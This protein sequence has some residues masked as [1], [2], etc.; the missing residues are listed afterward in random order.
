MVADGAALETETF[1]LSLSQQN[2]WNLEQAYPG[3]SINNISTTIRIQGRIDFNALQKSVNLVL[4]SDGSLRTRIFRS[5]GG[6]VQYHAPYTKEVFPVLDFSHTSAKGMESWEHA[7][8][9]EVIPLEDGPLYRFVLFRTGENSGGVLIKVHHIISDG[10]AQVLLCNRIGQTYLDLLSD[11]AVELEESPSYRL[12]VLEEQEYLKSSAYQKD[13]AYWS[14]VMRDAGEPSM[15]KQV[16]SAAVSPVG[17]RSSFR[18]PDVINH[19]IYSFC[20]QNRVAPF[21]VFYMALA[22]YF[23]RIGGAD[24]FT[25][26]VPIY[27][28][29]SFVSKQTTGMFVSTL[30]FIS[31]IHEEWSFSEFNERLAENWYELLRHQKFPFEDIVRMAEDEQKL[32]GRLFHIALSYQDSTILK[33]KDTSVHFSG[34]WHYNGYQAEHLCIHLSNL[35]DNRRY[36]VDYDYLTQ[37]YSDREIE[38]LHRCLLNILQEAL[39]A[40][41]RPI[42][43]LSVLGSE[44]REQVLYTFNRTLKAVPEEGLYR[45]FCRQVEEHPER[46]AAICDGARVS[47][48]ELEHMAYPVYEA[49]RQGGVMENALVAVFLPKKPELL[50]AMVGI[51]RAGCAYLLLS[52]DQPE[53]RAVDILKQSGA[54]FLISEEKVL[55]EAG[56]RSIP[57]PVLDMGSLAENEGDPAACAQERPE[58]LA[59][60]VYTSGSTGRPK[61]VEITRQNVSNFAQAMSGVYGKG[62]VLSICNVGFDAFM[63]ESIVPLLNGR[64]IVLPKEEDTESPERIAGLI[65]GYAVGFMALTPSRLTAFLKN[66]SFLEA[67]RSMESIVC[68]GEAFPGELLSKLQICSDAQI[69]NQY[70]PSEATVGVSMKLLNH[71]AQITAGPPMQNCRLYVLDD[72]MNPLPIGVYGNLYIGGACVGRGYRNEEQM[73]KESFLDNP[74][75]LGDR[76][77]RTGDTAR[78]TPEG[79]IVLGGRTDRQLKLRGVRLEPQEIAACLS[80][81]P[82]V[83]EAAVKVFA[84][85]SQEVL[86]A[87]Y[88]SREMLTEGELLAYAASYLPRYM[89]P[90]VI[91]RLDKIPLTSNGKVDESALPRPVSARENGKISTR[92]QEEL[93]GI[94]RT[95]LERE[96]LDLESDYFLYGGNSLNAMQVIYEIENKTGHTMRIAELY[97]CR[98]VRRLAEYLGDDGKAATGQ[99][100][101]DTKQIN[102]MSVPGTLRKLTPAPKLERYPLMP[103]QQGI[104]VQ[105]HFEDGQLAYHM[106]GA[107][108]LPEDVDLNRLQQAFRDLIA[109]DPVLRTSFH[110]DPD[111]VYA[112]VKDQV[113]FDIPVLQG[114]NREEVFG[115]FLRPFLLEE[116]PLL[117]AAYWHKPDGEWLLLVDMHHIIGDGLSTPLLIRRLDELYS[118]NRLPEAKVCYLDYAYEQMQG[119]NDPDPA[120]KEYWLENLNALPEALNLPADFARPHRFD[121]RG[122]VVTHRLPG[123]LSGECDAFCAAAGITSYTFFAAAFGLLLAKLS[124]KEDLVIGTPVSG[125]L[126]PQELDICGPFINTLPLRLQPKRGITVLEYMQAVQEAATGLLDHQRISQEEIIAMHKLPRSFSQNPLYQVMFSQRP[127]DAGEFKLAGETLAYHPIPMGTAKSDLTLETAKDKQGYFFCL[128]YAACLFLEE[129]AAYFGRCLEQIVEQFIKN[130]D[131]TLYELYP[132]AHTDQMELVDEPN[133]TYTPYLNLPIHKIIERTA[134]TDPDAAAVVFHGEK[135]TRAQLLNRADEIA[136]LLAAA[137]AAGGDRIGLIM[138]RSPD[139]FAAML[140]ILKAGCAYVPMLP[141][142]PEQRLKTM[143][144]TA[145]MRLILCDGR[146]KGML[147][148]ELGCPLICVEPQKNGENGGTDAGKALPAGKF[149]DVPVKGSDLVNVMFTSGSTGRPKGVMLKHSSVSNLYVSIRELLERAA[150]P[151]LCTTNVVFDSFI[152]E[153]LFPLAMG[154]VIVL[155]DEE[156]MMLPWKLADLIVHEDVEIFQVTPARLQMCLS[157][158]SF[159]GAANSLRLVLLGGEVLMPSLLQ[160][161]H[162]VSDAVSINMYGPTEATV[163]MTMIE[164]FPEKHIT[165]GRPLR[166]SRIYVLDENLRPVMPTA[167]GELCLAGEC[168]AAGYI[169]RPDLTEKAFVPDPFAPGELMYRSGDIGRLRLDGSYDFQGRRDAQVKLNGQRVELDEISGAILD[170]GFVVQAATVPVAKPDG[171]MELC[172]FYQAK[173]GTRVD[174]EKLLGHLKKLL[175]AYMLPS[176]F[177]SIEKMPY[178][179]SSKL[180]LQAL[181]KMA[182]TLEDTPPLKETSISETDAKTAGDRKEERNSIEEVKQAQ[183][184]IVKQE[185]KQTEKQI[186]KQEVKQT[187]KR[188]V[189]QEVKQTEKRIVQ[190]VDKQKEIQNDIQKESSGSDCGRSVVS[191]DVD[192]ILQIWSEVL[193]RKNLEADV[194]FFEQG[195]TSLAA[196]SVLSRYYNHQWELSLQE[197][198][199]NPSVIEQ[200]QILN[201]GWKDQIIVDNSKEP[202][203]NRPEQAEAT[204]EPE[205]ARGPETAQ[206]PE[207]ARG[208]EATQEPEAAQVPKAVLQSGMG[209]NRSR[210]RQLG[211][212]LL[213]GATGFM[214]AHLLHALIGAGAGTVLCLMRDGSRERL[215]E[216]L[217][218][219]F[220][221]G[222]IKSVSGRIKVIAGDISRP[223]L[224]LSHMNYID[225]VGRLDAIY[226]SAADVRHYASDAE[227]YISTNVT[228]VEHIIELAERS[229]AVLHHMSTCSVSGEQLVGLAGN[230]VFTEH[231]F[232]IGQDWQSNLY[233]K[234]KFL[235]EARV[236]DAIERGV[237]ARI[238][239]LG[240]LVGRCS[241]GTF[242]VNPDSNAFY[243]L[244]KGILALGVVPDTMADHLTDLTPVDYSADAVLALEGTQERVF[245]LMSP[246]QTRMEE[247]VRAI[248]PDTRFVPEPEFEKRLSQC[249]ANGY[250]ADLMPLADFWHHIKAAPPVI[251]VSAEYT[252][253]LLEK[254]GF[255]REIPGPGRLLQNF[256]FETQRHDG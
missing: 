217:S 178:T 122:K 87:Y 223:E 240:R 130:P 9:R 88:T 233:V 48:R 86:A 30:P 20:M 165:I 243:L 249:L 17:R 138:H 94:F 252:W 79:E 101:A 149:L 18:L 6:P 118:G 232:D 198:Y 73:T 11:K 203:R 137:G 35:E 22:I 157:N 125:R 77:Y 207:A 250:Q 52:T 199:E 12:H 127:L 219:Y 150:G 225:L 235:A 113:P 93:L 193:A 132:V 237:D 66:D 245:H 71:T 27:N 126:R 51:L 78:W 246:R 226:N 224:G 103:I 241:D 238:Y 181:K 221:A 81:H 182:A 50:A 110:Q 29:S 49:I 229:G 99:M 55:Q 40:Q 67:M 159:C 168:L 107:F 155:A 84:D 1:A 189:Q 65:T 213:T 177:V 167:C 242:Q 97:A 21:A 124:G 25:I 3:T 112:Y 39:Y 166:N 163:Y 123:P 197:F 139:L 231:D 4:A 62:A 234:T 247:I 179:P 80:S 70:G 230:A 95:V 183:K 74:F 254:Q 142:Y 136:G 7:V 61:G 251:E 176:R 152:G 46:A 59:Y 58:D 171:A 117:R 214:G 38:D 170:S 195:G 184:Q 90:T 239:R 109:W 23:K 13:L 145:G 134:E 45:Q 31:D 106:P 205:A 227:E 175:P 82:K 105:S 192:S 36:S 220:G 169:S 108:S 60:V 216:R 147:P 148:G 85:R 141:S 114:E 56:F 156:E 44:E 63:L 37:F 104:Y 209:G 200:L 236:F 129:T 204:Q 64:T 121:Y 5:G 228:G 75:V 119:E 173:D 68:G 26:G 16:K 111:G 210:S 172:S 151:I 53:G 158:T 54:K 154:K 83:K 76:I 116:A 191:A 135:I 133:F 42:Y 248:L 208:P 19:A 206:E 185:V 180:D 174:E 115:K 196:L 194:S 24:R 98:N 92:L 120:C 256:L 32:S 41:E 100:E 190:Q 102:V 8:T 14:G 215:L 201:P 72:W 153:S 140:G 144:E 143:R 212:V 96:D 162:Q 69:Y 131:Q 15:I 211:R 57:V 255:H 2:I 89:L 222:W 187:E 34:R 186:V 160:K 43:Q 91:I 164:V 47:Y 244:L 161:L 253:Q 128:E 28:R 202:F 33:S 188:I 10:W 146:A 218:W